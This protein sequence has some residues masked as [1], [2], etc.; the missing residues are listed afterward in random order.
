VAL[1][2]EAGRP[3]DLDRD[4]LAAALV[5]WC[6][7][8]D[9]YWADTQYSSLVASQLSKCMALLP[10]VTSGPDCQTWLNGCKR[11]MGRTLGNTSK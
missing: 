3:L 5:T 10:L 1:W 7:A 8:Q 4:A 6:S 11:V 9:A 2:E